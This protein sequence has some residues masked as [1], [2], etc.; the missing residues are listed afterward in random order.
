M[1]DFFDAYYAESTDGVLA[2][3]R[4]YE[5]D[6]LVVNERHFEAEYL[7]DGQFFFSPFNDPI[8]QMSGVRSNFVL[9]RIPDS[10]KAFQADALFV[11]EC[12]ADVLPGGG[13]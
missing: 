12:T 13:P 5:V 3:C 11:I 9:A 1:L 7:A 8:A 2:F 4:Q 6:Y 10:H